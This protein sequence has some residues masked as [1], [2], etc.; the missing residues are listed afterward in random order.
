MC[1]PAGRR[2]PLERLEA[3]RAPRPA[4]T[5]RRVPSDAARRQR[6]APRAAAGRP[7]LATAIVLGVVAPRPAHEDLGGPRR[8]PT[9]R[10]RSIGDDVG[11]ALTRNTGGAFSLFQAFTP[12]LAVLAIVLAVCSSGRCAAPTTR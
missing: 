4:S 10:S 7:V 3:L 9:G 1:L 12:L 5:A 8:S 6:P 11:F 2:I